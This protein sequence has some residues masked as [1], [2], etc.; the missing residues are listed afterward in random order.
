MRV[1]LDQ[2]TQQAGYD[3]AKIEAVI[4]TIVD[5]AIGM[6]EIIATQEL[7]DLY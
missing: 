5:A 1:F 6:R 4:D 7:K 2:R 3:Y